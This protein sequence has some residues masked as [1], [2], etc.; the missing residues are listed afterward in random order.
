MARQS[1]DEIEATDIR[2]PVTGLALITE[3]T[4]TIHLR[5]RGENSCAFAARRR[6]RDDQLDARIEMAQPGD[7]VGNRL[8]R[9]SVVA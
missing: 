7:R 9:W 8:P 3:G 5:R 1:F 4:T 6:W 2:R